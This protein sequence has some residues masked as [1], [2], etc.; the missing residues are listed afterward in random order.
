VQ[1]SSQGRCGVGGGLGLSGKGGFLAG[2]G[3]LVGRVE[4]RRRGYKTVQEMRSR[5]KFGVCKPLNHLLFSS[6]SKAN[7][8]LVYLQPFSM[9][10]VV[11]FLSTGIGMGFYFRSEKERLQRQRIA[12]ASK[13]VGKP[14]VGGAFELVDQDGRVWSSEEMKGRFS[15]VCGCC[16]YRLFLSD[17]FSRVISSCYACFRE[18]ILQDREPHTEKHAVNPLMLLVFDHSVT[19]AQLRRATAKSTDFG[20]LRGTVFDHAIAVGAGPCL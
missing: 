13:G 18:T 7:M 19:A 14:K 15:L 1:T 9:V 17:A 4:G 6:R 11:I 2:K 8:Y 5:Y 3:S 20:W 12:E 10:A 16:R